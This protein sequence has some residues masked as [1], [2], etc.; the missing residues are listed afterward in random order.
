MGNNFLNNFICFNKDK[1]SDLTSGGQEFVIDDE[2]SRRVVDFDFYSLKKIQNEYGSIFIYPNKDLIDL[3]N[4]IELF[5]FKTYEKEFVNK[6]HMIAKEYNLNEPII[7]IF[8]DNEVNSVVIISHIMS[9]IR[10][11][12]FLYHIYKIAI[13]EYKWITSPGFYKL[14]SYL[15][16]LEL[17]KDES[18]YHFYGQ[19]DLIHNA[20]TGV[21]DKNISDDE[22]KQIIK[23]IKHLD[24]IYDYELKEKIKYF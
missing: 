10:M 21:I 8:K 24:L 6:S 12:K 7:Q 2:L 22:L 5:I 23:K 18:L 4:E 3:I 19:K 17:I 11:T 14:H 16:W 9:V 15:E 13:V 20:I 1:L